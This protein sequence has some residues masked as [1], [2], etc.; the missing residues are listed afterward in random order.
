MRD[1]PQSDWEWAS[2]SRTAPDTCII[3]WINRTVQT[4]PILAQSIWNMRYIL[5][6]LE[7][8]N[9]DHNVLDLIDSLHISIEGM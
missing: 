8:K 6:D 1:S 4:S 5:Y 7:H 2:T 3:Y 9:G